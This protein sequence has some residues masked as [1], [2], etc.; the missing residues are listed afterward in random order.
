MR[1]LIYCNTPLHLIIAIHLKETR[2]KQDQVDLIMTDIMTG[3]QILEQRLVESAI[4]NTVIR[5]E[6]K[7]TP[8]KARRYKF[9]NHYKYRLLKRIF[10]NAHI[11]ISIFN[12]DEYIWANTGGI[13]L[14]LADYLKKT[15]KVLCLSMI[16][17]SFFT[18]SKDAE[19]Q[20]N[21]VLK[22]PIKQKIKQTYF[23]LF[24]TSLQKVDKFYLFKPEYLE[25]TPRCKIEKLEP[26]DISNSQIL[27]LYNT[28][29]NY[30][31]M[32]DS[33]DRNFIYFEES[34]YEDGIPTEDIKLV[35]KIAEMI[36]KDQIMVKIHP[37]NSVNRFHQLGYK[38]NAETYIPW[39]IIAMNMGN[40]GKSLIT[41]GSNS[42]I[43]PHLLLGNRNRVFFM[44]ECLEQ[45]SFLGNEYMKLLHKIHCQ[46]PTIFLL[47]HT[48]EE[49]A[50]LLREELTRGKNEKDTSNR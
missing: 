33:Y 41:M 37:R 46:N 10:T 20:F 19:K 12:Y 47:P 3:S 45:N 25:W 24:P 21:Y 30:Y 4:F 16:E 34:Y 28:I 2:F 22:D 1:V 13:G 7:K 39:E 32:T 9:I 23:K 17:D 38:T 18:Y 42:V 5:L 14:F 35:N 31:H 6:V 36:G 11:N 49:A 15:K 29:F 44:F 43:M 27:C 26:I 50:N 48:W 8:W 40:D